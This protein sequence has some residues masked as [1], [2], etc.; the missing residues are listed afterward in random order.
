MA[1]Q[2]QT[3]KRVEK[4]PEYRRC[5]LEYPRA[6]WDQLPASLEKRSLGLLSAGVLREKYKY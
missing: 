5:A 4:L 6:L 2:T 3:T 1:A